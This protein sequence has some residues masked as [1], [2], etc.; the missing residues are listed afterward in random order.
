MSV[1]AI[2]T[3]AFR[4]AAPARLGK[5]LSKLSQLFGAGSRDLVRWWTAD[6]FR[7]PVT[8]NVVL[9]TTYHAINDPEAVRRVLLDNVENY[10][11]PS[12][13]PRVFP[14]IMDGLFGAEGAPWR[15]QRR[16][17]APVFTPAAIGDFLPIFTAVAQDTAAN[18]E[19]SEPA[20]ID[21]AAAATRATFDVIS[22][23]LFSGEQGLASDEAADHVAAMLAGVGEVGIMAYLG[24]SQFS[25]SRRARAGR[26]GTAD[27]TQRITA[28][29]AR[30]QGDPIPP[31]DFMTRLID[32]F[33]AD[34]PPKQAARLALSN[35]VTF[36]VAGHETTANALAWTL[37]L[38]S[39]QPQVQTWAAEEAREALAAG[40][41]PGAV[42]DRL[43][44]LRWVLE[45]ALRLY[46]PAP[47]IDRQA[48][49]DDQLGDLVVKKGDYI[50]VW[51]WVLHRHQALWDNPDAFDPER[52]A[53]EA[54]AA[55]HRFQYIPFGA[56]P[57]VCIG[58][59]FATAEAL[60]ILTQ[61]LSRFEFSPAPGH[62]VE[63]QSDIA[64][65]PKGGLP[66][67]VSRRTPLVSR[68]E[69][70]PAAPDLDH[71]L[72]AQPVGEG[73]YADRGDHAEREGR[74]GGDRHPGRADLQRRP[75]HP[76]D[77]FAVRSAARAC[78]SRSSKSSTV[79]S[80]MANLFAHDRPPTPALP[81]L[82]RAHGGGS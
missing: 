59:Q 14:L 37:Y 65:R 35:A 80:L 12:L 52:F 64:L 45:E 30:R 49:A 60:L 19:S 9:G 70:F 71:A 53:P 51:P 32:A 27:L 26:R 78:A 13:L 17:M 66:L 3:P 41:G 54:K 28:F 5:P 58:A 43:V 63:V 62:K 79:S 61:W 74:T 48:L 72:G 56:G 36:L 47:R 46:P 31:A 82:T 7:E 25:P 75:I 67:I 50:G 76:V 68:W 39:E 24:L 81:P 44:Y 11:K 34:H 57:R 21:V 1:Q 40:G 73:E 10:P 23:T 77:Q 20:V 55:Q 42:L 4:P 69:A 18:W 38:L 22:R 6:S 8:T 33:A 2:D 16:L 15:S 29:I